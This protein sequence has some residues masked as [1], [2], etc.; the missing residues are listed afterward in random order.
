MDEAG[1]HNLVRGQQGCS[2]EV[3]EGMSQGDMPARDRAERV[4]YEVDFI[5]YDARVLRTEN[6]IIIL[7][8]TSCTY[9]LKAASIQCKLH[10]KVNDN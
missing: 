5:I 10:Q 7:R 1:A 4:K 6:T 3:C 2:D 9:K 8:C